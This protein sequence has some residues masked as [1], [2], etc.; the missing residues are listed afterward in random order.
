MASGASSLPV[1]GID[2]YGGPSWWPLSQI[3]A[4]RR[5]PGVRRIAAVWLIV[6]LVSVLTGV[7][8]VTR[9]WN[10]IPVTIGPL[11]FELTV[12]PPLVLGLACAVWLGPFWGIVPAYLANL[13]SSLASGIAWPLGALFSLAGA[14]EIAIFWGSMVTLN[15][16]PDLRR[17]RDLV[18]FAAVALVAPTTSS[19]AVIIWNTAHGLDFLAGQSTWRGWVLGDLFQALVVVAPMLHWLGRPVRTLIDRQFPVSPRQSLTYT[20]AAFLSFTVFALMGVLVFVGI[21]MLQSSLDIDPGTRTTRGEPLGPRL[22]EVELFLGLLVIA[23]I[24][25]T[26]VFSTALARM[27]ERQRSLAY[28]E[29][30]TGCFNRRAFQELFQREADRSRRLGQSVSL[31][32]LDVDHF[33]AI[34]D[35]RGHETGD[36]LLQQ[37]A[38]RVQTVVR[39][40]DL[41]FRWGGEE[42]VILLP[43]TSPADARALAERV[44]AAVAER[45][46]LGAE[47]NPGVRMTVS[48]GTAGTDALAASAEALLARADAACYEAKRQGRNRVVVAPL[49]PA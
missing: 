23:S 16:S 4:A 47:L 17:F 26:G 44:R 1:M 5:H 10:A 38:M 48:L 24:V 8:N 3:A 32:F 33:K 11:R 30:L 34:N 6:N 21:G 12:Y 49:L 27:G 43:H 35:E 37:L 28:R 15:V 46:F 22:F 39:E 42:F 19:L 9:G 25:A 20:R 31:A 29:S 13:G 2:G 41:L 40:T 45:P 7:L 18:R 14:I 36:R